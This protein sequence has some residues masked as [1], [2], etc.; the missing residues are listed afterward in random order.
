MPRK[1]LGVPDAGLAEGV[2]FWRAEAGAWAGRDCAIFAP[3]PSLAPAVVALAEQRPGPLTAIAI[4]DAWEL[5]RWAAIVYHCDVAWWA[6]PDKAGV[7]A[8]AG[9]KLALHDRARPP[10][11]GVRVLRKGAE[12]GYDPDP[13]VLCTGR[14]SGYQAIHLA[15]HYR[16]RRIV[17]IG[18]DMRMVGGRRH[19][20]GDHP[21]G[22]NRCAIYHDYAPAFDH[23]AGAAAELGVEIL[24]ATPGSAVTAFPIVAPAEAF[25]RA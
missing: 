16:P 24:N 13:G 1:G 9:F 18:F 25:G 17:L 15:L 19:F 11:A 12:T 7:F 10:P 4:G 14:N 2:R 21:A 3:G 20:F 6:H 23:L 5:C 22:L 8:H